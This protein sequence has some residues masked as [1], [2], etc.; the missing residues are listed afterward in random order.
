M[1]T[2]LKGICAD[3]KVYKMWVETRKL[4]VAERN[5]YLGTGA[6]LTNGEGCLSFT[7]TIDQD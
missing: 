2:L 3:R 1:V 5:L 7:Y 4:N 6:V